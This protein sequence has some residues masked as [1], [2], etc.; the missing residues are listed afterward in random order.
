MPRK[1]IDQAILDEVFYVARMLA[2]LPTTKELA[3]RGKCSQ[4]QIQYHLHKQ[5]VRERRIRKLALSKQD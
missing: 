5:L 2:R 3:A 1:R 4:R